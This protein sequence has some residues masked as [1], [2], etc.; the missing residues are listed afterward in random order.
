[1][2]IQQINVQKRKNKSFPL[3]IMTACVIAD[4]QIER[5]RQVKRCVKREFLTAAFPTVLRVCI[6]SEHVTNQT[7]VWEA[8]T[9]RAPP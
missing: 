9:C 2:W 5:N 1:M 3:E 7:D 8:D 4:S 6:T